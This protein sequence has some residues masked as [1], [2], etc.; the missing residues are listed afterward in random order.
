MCHRALELWKSTDSP[1]MHLLQRQIVL[2]TIPEGNALFCFPAGLH[3]HVLTPWMHECYHREEIPNIAYSCDFLDNV[4]NKK[5]VLD[6][7]WYCLDTKHSARAAGVV[8]RNLMFILFHFWNSK[9]PTNRPTRPHSLPLFE[10]RLDNWWFMSPWQQLEHSLMSP[11]RKE[12]LFMPWEVM[13]G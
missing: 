12:S 6:S 9:Q 2:Y 3:F 8:Y 13:R 7:E 1:L 10:I 11:R 4:V 5:G